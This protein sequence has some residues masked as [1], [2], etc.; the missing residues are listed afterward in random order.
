MATKRLE[1]T[2]DNALV[3]GVVA[4][5]AKYFDQDPVLFRVIAI[6]VSI[7]SGFFPGVLVYLLAWLIMPK[8][9]PRSVPPGDAHNKADYT[10]VE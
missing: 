9:T 7:F 3:A 2:D 1:R 4:G 5:I 6:A 10:V 8:E